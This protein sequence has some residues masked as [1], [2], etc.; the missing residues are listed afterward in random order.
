MNDDPSETLVIKVSRI[1][2]ECGVPTNIRGYRY[3]RRAIILTVNDYKIVHQ[4]TKELYPQI[5][6]LEDT[7]PARVERAIRHAIEVM[8][9]F[10]GVYESEILE[11]VFKYSSRNL[12]YRPT[13]SEFIAGLAEHIRR[14]KV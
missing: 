9:G 10:Q 3:L 11:D 4:I 8:W 5:A 12:A 14:Y 13:N 6:K 1:L 2:D 7:T